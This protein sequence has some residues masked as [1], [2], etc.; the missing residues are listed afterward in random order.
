[1]VGIAG[2]GISGLFLLHL[3][4][5]AGLE[6]ILFERSPSVGGVMRSRFVEGP[7]GRVPVDLRPQRMRLGGAFAGL[8][9]ELGLASA[10]RNN[11]HP[12]E[13]YSEYPVDVVASYK[14]TA[15]DNR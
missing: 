3:V 6:A 1:M 12:L 7:D 4:R 14:P 10:I 11:T 5:A 9:E 8:S 2:G 13:T 15:V